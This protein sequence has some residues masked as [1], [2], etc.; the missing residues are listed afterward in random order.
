MTGQSARTLIEWIQKE[1]YNLKPDEQAFMSRIRY[2]T[3]LTREQSNKVQ[4]IYARATNGGF[5]V[6][7]NKA[8][9]YDT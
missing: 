7:P 5:K 3:R 1:G 6:Y 4:E 8:R 2:A 9:T